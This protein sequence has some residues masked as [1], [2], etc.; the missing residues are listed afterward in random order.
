MR[1]DD[2]S[3]S[4]QFSSPLFL[5]AATALFV[6]CGTS[7][8]HI[9]YKVH[10]LKKGTLV[11][12]SASHLFSFGEC[13]RDFR[14]LGLFVSKEFMEEM[15]STDMIYR[16]IK[17]GVRLYNMP[18]IRLSEPQF[19]LLAERVLAIERTIADTDHL[20]QKE[21]ILNHLFTFYLDLSNILDRRT[22]FQGENN[23][24]RYE[25]II[26]SF[27]EL[28]V[29]HYRKEHKVAFYASHLNIS[30]HY[31]TLIVK[32]ITGQSVRDF[33][34]EMLYSE[35]RNLLSHSKLSI[36]EI[37]VALNFSDQS[38]FGKFFKRKSGISPLDYRKEQN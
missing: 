2:K 14:C 3:V 33:I 15:D 5:N 22:G 30:A 21:M 36:Q 23:L 38:S 17:Y 20:Y 6:L 11:I 27:I 37:T 16:R 34:F 8:I 28:L 19:A 13:S 35:A 18:V 1:L 10:S 24:N 31:L 7:S 25:S 26:K 4:A 12:L 32:R 29:N 9:N